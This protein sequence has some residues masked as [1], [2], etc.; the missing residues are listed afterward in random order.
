MVAPSAEEVG[1]QV[2]YE[3]KWMLRAVVRFEEIATTA[4]AG[5]GR[6]K[7]PPD[8]DV[9]AL[10]DSAL[11]HARNLVEFAAVAPDEATSHVQ[12][13]LVDILGTHRRKVPGNRRASST[14]GSPNS[15]S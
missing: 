14:A 10:Q 6:K 13:A 7:D 2:C 11:L 4:R 5:G 12:W 1:R 3:L 8:L 15:A 9:V